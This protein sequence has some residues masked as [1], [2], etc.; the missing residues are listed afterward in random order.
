MKWVSVLLLFCLPT[1]CAWS[2]MHIISGVVLDGS[3]ITLLKD[4]EV[5]YGNDTASVRKTN[6]N[7]AF[8]LEVPA[9]GASLVL[10]LGGYKTMVQKVLPGQRFATFF[11]YPETGKAIVS[12]TSSARTGQGSL[13]D[14]NRNLPVAVKA[15]LDET[16]EQALE[17][18]FESPVDYP[19][20]S[21]ILNADQASYCNIRRFIT[22]GLPP[23]SEAV[24]IE[25]MVNYFPYAYPV[26]SS[27]PMSL[28]ADVTTCPWHDG[29]WLMRLAATARHLSPDTTVANNLV[30]LIDVSGSMEATNKLPLLKKAFSSLIN[31]LDSADRL[32]I[33]V[34]AGDVSVALPSTPGYE[35]NKILNV[36]SNLNAGGSTAGGAGI[37]LA[38]KLAKLNYLSHGNNRV[39]MATDGDFNVGNTSDADMRKLVSKYHNWGIYLTCIGVGKGNYK[40]SKLETLARW[41]QGNFVYLDNSDE[42][43]RI[44]SADEYRKILIPVVKNAIFKVVFNPEEIKD[45]RLIG[46]ENRSRMEKDTLAV[47][48]PGGEI[49][50]GQAITAFYELDPVDKNKKLL[51]RSG[52]STETSMMS[53]EQSLATIALLYQT[54]ADSVDHLVLKNIPGQVISFNKSDP[55]FQFASAVTLFGMILRQSAYLGEGDLDMVNKITRH[56]RDKKFDKQERKSFLKLIQKADKIK[57]NTSEIN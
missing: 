49:G 2:Q 24:R 50:Y 37:E 57:K 42:A 45:Y 52:S 46:Y 40:D 19:L 44:F 12:A 36:I 41:G 33:V 22:N 20:S 21:F 7:G 1:C 47:N 9:A 28:H 15:H 53:D 31:R 4:V 16:Y 6:E 35:K 23:P 27:A 34:Y 29:H 25:E 18:P 17:N 13:S 10:E 8:Q 55:G 26:D 54:I 3:T 5:Y 30:L 32:A 51:E 39:I 11:L 38:F 14:R 48:I 56:I 43:M